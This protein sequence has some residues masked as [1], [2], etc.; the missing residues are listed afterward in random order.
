MP[1]GYPSSGPV[2][3]E[4]RVYD[5]RAG[6]CCW[7]EVYGCAFRGWVPCGYS[8]RPGHL[9]CAKHVGLDDA[10]KELKAAKRRKGRAA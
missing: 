4:R 1:K 7:V 2:Q 3:G 9:T 6:G 8:A 5:P 10:A